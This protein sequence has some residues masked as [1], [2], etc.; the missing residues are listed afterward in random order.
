MNKYKLPLNLYIKRQKPFSLIHFVTNRCNARCKH[1]FID[2]NNKDSFKDELSIQEIEKLSKSL[3]DSLFNLNLTG[4]EPFLR[5]DFFNIVKV[6]LQN[7]TIESIF[8]NTNGY[9]SDLIKNFIDQLIVLDTNKKVIFSIS[10]DNFESE[11]DKFRNTKG[12]FKRALE[13]YNLIKNYNMPNVIPNIGITV[14]DHNYKNVVEVYEHLKKKGIKS[15]TAT[16]FREEGV[17]KYIDSKLKKKILKA[18][19][20]LTEKIYKDQLN[21][22]MKGF[23]DSLQGLMMNA[24]NMIL[25][26]IIKET[27]INK[28]FI[29]P[30]HAG[31]LFGIIYANGD[32]YPCEIFDMKLGNLRD[33]NMT[34]MDLWNSKK[35]KMSRKLIKKSKCNC[36]F[37]CALS[38]NILSNTRCLYNLLYKTIILK[39]Q[40]R[41]FV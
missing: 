34:F 11:H 38:I 26:S 4:G 8:I 31:S 16:I 30:C 3:G 28:K 1:C 29:V 25:T 19:S 7:T 20:L 37:E 32:V 27:Y 23:G 6:Y 9:F 39:W 41:K 40:K 35:T 18:Y 21:G 33:Y 14:S 10:I 5:K 22:E 36:T 15:I 24:K 2:F 12:L 17:I 13:S